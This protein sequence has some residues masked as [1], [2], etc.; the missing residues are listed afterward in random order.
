MNSPLENAL[1][2]E[3]LDVDA[4]T[5]TRLHARLAAQAEA[6]GVLEMMRDHPEGELLGERTWSPESDGTEGFY[7]ALWRRR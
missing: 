3:L 4:A 1:F 7:A 5:R 2:A 6:T